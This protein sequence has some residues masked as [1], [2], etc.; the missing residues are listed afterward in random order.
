MAESLEKIVK[1][2]ISQ[3][4][5]RQ[6]NS[7]KSELPYFDLRFSKEKTAGKDGLKPLNEKIFK[8]PDNSSLAKPEHHYQADRS[9]GN[10]YHILGILGLF[11]GTALFIIPN[12]QP[13]NSKKN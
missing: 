2:I 1:G 3:A 9:S 13:N 8:Y 4:E 7:G 10:I 5:N 11:L 6:N 12:Y